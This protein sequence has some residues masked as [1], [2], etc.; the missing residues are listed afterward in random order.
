MDGFLSALTRTWGRGSYFGGQR[1]KMPAYGT[2]RRKRYG[3]ATT[4]RRSTFG[5][6]APRRTTYRRRYAKKRKPKGKVAKIASKVRELT[7]ETD[8]TIGTQT[9]RGLTAE[10]LKSVTN[11]QAIGTFYPVSAV[12]LESVLSNLKYYD[13]ANPGVLVVAPAATG[14]YQ[15][16][17]LFKSI[18]LSSTFRN[19]YQTGLTL[20]IY[21]NRARLD[22]N[23][24]P[25]VAW[26]NGVVDS[27]NLAVPTSLGCYPT[28]TDL[29]K[30]QWS[31][32]VIKTV[33]LKPGQSTTVTATCPEFEYNPA[34]YDTDALAFSPDFGG[35][36]AFTYVLSG[37]MGHDTILDQTGA[38]AAGVDISHKATYVVKYSA[39][40][41]ISY[42]HVENSMA[43][44]F[45][46]T[47]VEGMMVTDNQGYSRA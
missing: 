28:D 31:W 1:R 35:S 42:V 38:L 29:A 14:S 16:K 4:S 24:N 20:R 23:Q 5:R 25:L 18:F 39:G 36:T 8:S 12:L 15:K 45:T 32:K 7:R 34:I 13:P 43:S 2:R 30:S 3:Y 10:S 27:S 46:N 9:Y 21:L 44:A 41:N 6:K 37:D 26:T 33:H 19:S 22:G 11:Q 40:I 17:I 47:G